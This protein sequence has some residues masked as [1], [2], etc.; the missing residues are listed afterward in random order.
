M[1]IMTV[2]IIQTRLVV[3]RAVQS[4]KVLNSSV[5]KR[6]VVCITAGFAMAKMTAMMA[7]MREGVVSI[8]SLL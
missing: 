3:R 5:K 2:K 6:L 8:I 1:V 4:A 7:Q